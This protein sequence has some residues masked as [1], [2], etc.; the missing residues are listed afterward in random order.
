ML[1]RGIRRRGGAALALGA[2]VAGRAARAG[3]GGPD[4]PGELAGVWEWLWQWA[5]EVLAPVIDPGAAK[6][7]AGRSSFI[8]PNG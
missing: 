8:D 7:D 5:A 4:T 1:W 2:A 6:S 3:A